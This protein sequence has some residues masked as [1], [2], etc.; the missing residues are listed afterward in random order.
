MNPKSPGWWHAGGFGTACGF[1]PN[2]F[3][4]LLAFLGGRPE[5]A[6]KSGRAQDAAHSITFYTI[7]TKQDQPLETFLHADKFMFEPVLKSFKVLYHGVIH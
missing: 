7:A 4:C 2:S 3:S 6:R 1:R 5:K